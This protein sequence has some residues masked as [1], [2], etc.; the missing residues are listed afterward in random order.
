MR[1]R[2]AFSEGPRR[3]P[4]RRQ[5]SCASLGAL[6]TYLL[7]E[8]VSCFDAAFVHDISE[9]PVYFRLREATKPQRPT[10]AGLVS[11]FPNRNEPNRF[12]YFFHDFTF[13]MPLFG[14]SEDLHDYVLLLIT[15]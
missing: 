8:Q 14:P 12:D 10:P 5:H 7:T 2:G 6:P 11:H 13:C 9:F 1:E 15:F 4:G 3:C